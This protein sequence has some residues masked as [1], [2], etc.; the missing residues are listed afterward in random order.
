MEIEIKRHLNLFE[1]R[2]KYAYTNF[3]R[4]LIYGFSLFRAD[5]KIASCVNSF[6]NS[7]F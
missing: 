6:Y 5:F 4:G 3:K 2:D 1:P 7:V